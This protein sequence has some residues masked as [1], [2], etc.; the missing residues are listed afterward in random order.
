MCV[1]A[2]V[3]VC[4]CMRDVLAIYDN[5]TLLLLIRIIIKIIVLYFI[6]IVHTDDSPQR[7]PD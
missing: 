6:E 2:S 3:F 5:N 7:V 4:V 1:C